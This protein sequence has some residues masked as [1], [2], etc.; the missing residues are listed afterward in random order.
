MLHSDSI[1][2]H[3]PHCRVTPVR[4]GVLHLLLHLS[5]GQVEAVRLEYGIPSKT[6]VAPSGYNRTMCATIEQMGLVLRA[7][8]AKAISYIT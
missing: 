5:E 2:Q 6:W 3:T 1:A 4:D 7:C 8:A